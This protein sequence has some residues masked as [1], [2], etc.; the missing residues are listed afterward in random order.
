MNTLAVR[1]VDGQLLTEAGWSFPAPVG[2]RLPDGPLTL[3]VRPEDVHLSPEGQPAT[4]FV[5]EPLGNEVIVNVHVG[6]TLVKLR[7]AP[8]IRPQ[9]GETV[10][11]RAEPSRLHIFDADGS[12]LS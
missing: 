11:L 4:V 2:P 6:Q 12:R 1:R 8:S 3:G 9:R 10:F 5:S 7:A